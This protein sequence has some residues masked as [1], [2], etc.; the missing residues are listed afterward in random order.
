MA[1]IWNE[2]GTRDVAASQAFYEAVAGWGCASMPMPGSSDGESYYL[3]QQNGKDVAGMFVMSGPA[4]D[5]VPC[6]WLGYIGVPDVDAAIAK[7]L[8]QGGQILRP[9]FD[10]PTIGR[11]AIVS[12]NAG[13]V[14]ALMT[15]VPM[16]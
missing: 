9:A 6:G 15:P 1:V 5:G 8:E 12:D 3:F 16:A 10:V 7:A 13:A 11:I 2:L 4:F 14:V